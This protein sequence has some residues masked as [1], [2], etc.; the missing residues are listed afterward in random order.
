MNVHSFQ[1]KR[2]GILLGPP[3]H[4]RYS[5]F[6]LITLISAGPLHLKGFYIEIF[7]PKKLKIPTYNAKYNKM[8]KK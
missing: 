8:R 3:C 4:P 5:I 6:F 1:I 7:S 2:T